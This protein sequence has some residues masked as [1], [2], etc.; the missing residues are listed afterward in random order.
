MKV[1]EWPLIY[2]VWV[3]AEEA[4]PANEY[5]MKVKGIVVA[6]IFKD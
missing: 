3:G 4:Q 5:T 1:T 2:A 6:L